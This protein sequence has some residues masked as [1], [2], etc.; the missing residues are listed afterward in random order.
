MLSATT[1][2]LLINQVTHTIPALTVW[3]V[4]DLC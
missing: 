4:S 1:S 2:R 3:E